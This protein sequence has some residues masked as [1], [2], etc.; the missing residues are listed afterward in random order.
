MNITKK[1]YMSIYKGIGLLL[2]ILFLYNIYQSTSIS[3]MVK[4]KIVAAEEAARPA[5][6]QLT[7]I[8]DQNCKD[9]F[10]INTIAGSLKS[11]NVNI[12]KE[13]ALYLNSKEAKDL[14]AKYGL[15]KIPAIILVGETSK[16]KL[17]GFE[18][19]NDA[20][21]FNQVEPPYT[22]TKLNQVVGRVSATIIKDSSCEKCFDM[23]ALLKEI[24]NA[25]VS[26]V[27]ENIIEKGSNEANDIIEK[28]LI[29]TL[30]AMILSKDLAEY[31]NIVASWKAIGT[32]ESDG[33]YIVRVNNP[34]YIN[35]TTGKVVGMVDITYLADKSC[36]ECYDPAA[37]HNQIISRLGITLN[38]KV[39][40][41][42][43]DSG[44]KALVEKYKIT[45]LP[46]IILTGDV[47]AYAGLVNAWKTVG[48][49][50]SDSAYVF[51]SVEIAEEPYKDLVKNE[52]VKTVA[53]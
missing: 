43:A 38:N 31:T 45:K 24:K 25:K 39:N 17:D 5:I 35:L 15:A 30:P 28:Y 27:S 3:S 16:V 51:R 44:G 29:K 14:I 36:T 53:K 23:A 52:V 9:C 50:E 46:T 26:I 41:D 20:L 19:N 37:F 8:E 4:E 49:V 40:L 7:T 33:S 22:N 13:D 42:A 12:T 11:N 2:L 21:I 10:N 6:L 18:L 48:T 32:V 1:T 47:G 34:I